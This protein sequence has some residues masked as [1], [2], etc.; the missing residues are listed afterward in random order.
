MRIQWITEFVEL[1]RP[2]TI[3]ITITI[4]I[5]VGAERSR[6]NRFVFEDPVGCGGWEWMVFGAREEEMDMQQRRA[7]AMGYLASLTEAHGP[8]GH[9]GPVRALVREDWA[10]W[11]MEAD[12]LGGIFATVRENEA[13]PRVLLAGHMD[14]VGFMVQQITPEGFLRFQTLGGW[15]AH[16]LLAQRV[17]IRIRAG[18]EIIGVIASVPPHFLSSEQQKQ[19]MELDKLYID[20]GAAD[21][22]EVHRMGIRVGDPVAPDGAFRPMANPDRLLSKAFDNRVGMAATMQAARELADEDLPCTLIAAGTVQEEVGLR[23][24]RT[25]GEAVRPDVALVMEGPPADDTPGFPIAEA[26]GKLGGGVQIR[27]RDQSAIMN[28]ALV[29]FARDVAEQD[30]IPHQVTVRRSGGTDAGGFQFAGSGIPVVVLGVPARYIHT[31]NAIIDLRDYF[32]ALDLIGALVRRFDT[33]RI[34]SLTD[35]LSG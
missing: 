18:T 22:E 21:A 8:P 6:Y 28:R 23:G 16:T 10:D 7:R 25:L 9:E 4:R 1:N 11:P 14:E 15:W 29:D 32:A 27:V 31:H 30:G 17:R 26:Q 2:I 20:V 33:E 19:V 12:G 35:Y 24:A 34:R 3:R 5:I 13:G